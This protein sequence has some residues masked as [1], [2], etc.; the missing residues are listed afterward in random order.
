[1]IWYFSYIYRD[2]RCN[3]DNTFELFVVDIS[4][5]INDDG[6]REI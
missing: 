5:L 1:M 2:D 4:I 3:N 6:R